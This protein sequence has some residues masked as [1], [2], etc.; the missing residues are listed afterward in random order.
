MVPLFHLYFQGNKIFNCLARKALGEQRKT[1][2]DTLSRKLPT[3]LTILRIRTT[4]LEKILQ[5][6][7][8]FPGF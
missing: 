5:N 8:S 1:K 2:E 6:V 3:M 4:N 7:F